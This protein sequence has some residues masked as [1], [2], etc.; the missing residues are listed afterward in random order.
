MQNCENT[1]SEQDILG[2]KLPA[3]NGY[4][5]NG[6][7][8]ASSDLPGQDTRIPGFLPKVKVPKDDWQTRKVAPKQGVPTHPNMLG[9]TKKANETVPGYVHR[10]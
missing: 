1:M 6:Y 2:S 4:G 9:P 7:D 10:G 8:G 3:D 5:Q